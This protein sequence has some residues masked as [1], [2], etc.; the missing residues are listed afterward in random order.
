MEPTAAS[1]SV[2]RAADGRVRLGWRLLTFAGAASAV[3]LMAML[4][5]PSGDLTSSIALLLGGLVGGAVAL[6]LDGRPAGALGFYIA[7]ESVAESLAGLGLGGGVAGA[8]V[9]ALVVT[10]AL[11]WT[12]EPGSVAGWLGHAGGALL[13]LAVPAATEEA[14]VRGYP[15]QALAEAWGPWWAL[16]VTAVAFGALHLRNPGVTTIGAVNVGVAGLFLGVVYLRTGS[17]WCA[18]GAHLGWNF[19]HGYLA[20]VPVSGLELLNAP[21]YEGVLRGPT[22]LSGGAFGPEGSL[23]ATVV[24]SAA[25]VI[26]WRAKWLRPSEV[27]LAARPL[28][29]VRSEPA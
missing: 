6:A 21:L 3:M 8:V 20:D 9:V 13:F 4:A 16:C 12:G 17:L 14:L 22:W 15:L 18:S 28:A 26:C 1:G 25:V 2:L 23:L 5:L 10:G 19:T 29:V 24:V 27:A 11:R 7:R